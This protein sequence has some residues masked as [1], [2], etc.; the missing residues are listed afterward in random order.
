MN[1]LKYLTTKNELD[2]I[3]LATSLTLCVHHCLTFER[4]LNAEII[5]TQIVF[6]KSIGREGKKE[7]EGKGQRGVVLEKSIGREE[8]KEKEGK[9]QRGV[10]P[11][12]SIWREE[13]K[14]KEGKGQRG[15]DQ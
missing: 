13:K 9:G 3:L 4:T 6:E 11:K 12:K 8:K 14:E 10:V 2:N 15:D 7:K 5:P 1:E